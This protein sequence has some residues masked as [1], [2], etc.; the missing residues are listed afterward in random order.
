MGSKETAAMSCS[1]QKLR[2]IILNSKKAVG[3]G[4]GVCVNAFLKITNPVFSHRL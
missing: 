3:G 1:T 2:K 4:G